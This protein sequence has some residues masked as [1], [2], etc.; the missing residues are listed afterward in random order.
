[1]QP[2]LPRLVVPAGAIL[3][4]GPVWHTHEQALYWLDIKGLRVHRYTPATDEATSWTVPFRIG[5][6]APRQAGGFVGGSEH[7]LM[8]INADFTL[9]EPIAHPEADQPGNRANDGKVDPHGR[10]WMGTI[11]DAE[12]RA[13]GSLYRFD[14]DGRWERVDGGYHV[15]NGPAFSPDGRTMYHNDSA[16]QTIYRFDVAHDGSA[17]NRRILAQFSDG[18]GY[19]DGMTVDA[20]GCLWVAFWDGWCVRRLS[21]SGEI[22]LKIDLPIQRPTSCAFGGAALDQLYI[23]SASIDLDESALSDQP[24]AGGLFVVEPGVRGIAAPSFA[25]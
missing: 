21:P 1:M 25:G 13:I 23:T 18:D 14:A 19:P 15:T 7:G 8:A 24:G 9:F 12:E 6:L 17:S 22:M 20:S 3:G 4:E 10:F 11:D 16:L 2:A 5:S